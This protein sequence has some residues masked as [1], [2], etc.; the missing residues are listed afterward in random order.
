MLEDTKQRSDIL[1]TTCVGIRLGSLSSDL[2]G[3][4]ESTC[5]RPNTQTQ[6]HGIL[7]TRLPKSVH[8]PPRSCLDLVIALTPHQASER[9]RL[10]RGKQRSALIAY[11]DVTIHAR[12]VGKCAC[13][14][15][16]LMQLRAA[17]INAAPAPV[18]RLGLPIELLVVAANDTTS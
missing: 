9:P 7:M 2:K 18:T 1:R 11:F 4:N 6:A 16:E 15:V 13:L 17:V 12:L 8:L 5:L 3:S 10:L 14:G